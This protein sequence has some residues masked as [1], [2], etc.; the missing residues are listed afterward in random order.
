M[1][2]RPVCP[3]KAIK[4]GGGMMGKFLIPHFPMRLVIS[5]DLFC[6]VHYNTHWTWCGDALSSQAT[7]E[8]I[9]SCALNKQSAKTQL[10][11]W[12]IGAFDSAPIT[13]HANEGSEAFWRSQH[14]VKMKSKWLLH[15]A[16]LLVF[17]VMSVPEK[18][19]RELFI[20]SSVQR[21]V[22]VQKTGAQLSHR[23]ISVD[24]TWLG[25]LSPLCQR[26]QEVSDLQEKLCRGIWSQI[27]GDK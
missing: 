4:T 8:A 20:F 17:P 16:R 22:A 19:Y 2:H 23:L 5:S 1:F 24:K 10:N 13:P 21:F 27:Q 11:I 7:T 12:K 18:S 9:V 3:G 15:F 26:L 6:E 25:A 14:V